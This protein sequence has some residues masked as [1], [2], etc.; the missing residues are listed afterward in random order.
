MLQP[1]PTETG[2]TPVWSSAPPMQAAGENAI[3]TLPRLKLMQALSPDVVSQLAKAGEF[4]VEGYP[5]FKEDI[6][7]IPLARS[8][9]RI[10]RD[11]MGVLCRSADAITGVGEPGGNCNTCEY[12]EWGFGN[13]APCTEIFTYLVYIPEHD[14]FARW[15]L[16][17]SGMPCAK[18]L[19]QFAM[20]G[21]GDF[22]VQIDATEKREKTFSYY[23][24]V[25]TKLPMTAELKAMAEEA[26]ELM[27][28][29][30]Q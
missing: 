16:Q 24:P 9:S 25:P 28:G 17:K 1:A 7:I 18:R 15:A 29:M 11:D 30:S 27:R 26:I 13:A 23:V 21:W 10:Y 14:V 4:R 20:R 8:M 12:A 22:A 3:N 19:D 5:S 2:L 6:V